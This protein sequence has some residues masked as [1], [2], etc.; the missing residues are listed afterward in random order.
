MA[1]HRRR[2]LLHPSFYRR[3]FLLALVSHLF[4][5]SLFSLPCFRS[6]QKRL[7]KQ[8]QKEA[9][10]AA[11]AAGKP[12]SVAGVESKKK[13]TKGDDADDEEV[14]PTAYFDQRV[15]ELTEMRA[16]GKHRHLYPHKFHAS[17]SIPQFQFEFSQVALSNGQRMEREV[18]V[19]GRVYVKRS[20]GASLYFYDLQAQGGAVQVVADKKS[21]KDDWSIHEHIKRGSTHWTLHSLTALTH[22]PALHHTRH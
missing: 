20:S 6:A 22:P 12:P 17:M 13:K 8:A 7:Q 21:D 5:L 1:R 16:S 18:S 19:A 2:H 15:R 14:D 4:S 9:E 3:P 11:K 10:K